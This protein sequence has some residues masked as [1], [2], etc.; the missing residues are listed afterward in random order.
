MTEQTK[1]WTVKFSDGTVQM[2][3]SLEEALEEALFEMKLGLDH[4]ILTPD[5]GVVWVDKDGTWV[6]EV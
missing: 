4:D 5:G 3:S 2:C 1:I 6:S